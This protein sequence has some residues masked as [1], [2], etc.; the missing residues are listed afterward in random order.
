MRSG[1]RAVYKGVEYEYIT[2]ND[3]IYKLFVKDSSL[4][5]DDF[6]LNEKGNYQKFVTR[7]E[8]DVLYYIDQFAKYK[9]H[10]FPIWETNGV[11]LL[12]GEGSYK[13][14]K[15]VGFPPS[16][17]PWERGLYKKWIPKSDIEEILEE[18]TP[19]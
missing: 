17:L 2:K 1:K 3:K 8:I 18:K 7:D 14:T 11:Q 6:E 15:E 10:K 16:G 13:I 12:L 5:P 4:A 19:L 9:G